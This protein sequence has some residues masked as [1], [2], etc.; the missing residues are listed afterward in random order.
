MDEFSDTFACSYDELKENS[1]EIVEY[2][3]HFI[4]GIRP[5]RQKERIMD[6][7]LLLLVRAELECY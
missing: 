5:I 7:Q 1:R 3:I 2:R 4:P 6:P